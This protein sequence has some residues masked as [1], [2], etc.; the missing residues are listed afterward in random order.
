MP[1]SSLVRPAAE[2][3]VY[4]AASWYQDKEPE[5]PLWLDLLDEFEA[6]LAQLC[7]F[8]ESAPVYENNVRRA[9]L[10]RFPY[11]LYYVIESEQLVVLRFLAMDLELGSGTR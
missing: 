10:S 5:L 8:P 9:L 7:E 3:A 2:A 11:A 4:S 1:L 6:V